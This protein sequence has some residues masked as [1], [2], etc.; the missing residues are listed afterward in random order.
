MIMIGIIKK[1]IQKFL[2]Y[3]LNVFVWFLKDQI[4]IPISLEINIR[5]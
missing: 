2:I 4:L 1:K 5:S 3:L